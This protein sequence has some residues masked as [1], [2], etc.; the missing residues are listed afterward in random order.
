MGASSG[1]PPPSG[2]SAHIDIM[3]RR[4]DMQ[5]LTPPSTGG[6]PIVVQQG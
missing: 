3:Q 4:P 2:I 1:G 6:P 5:A